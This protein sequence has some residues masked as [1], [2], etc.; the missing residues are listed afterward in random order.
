MDVNVLVAYVTIATVVASAF[1][2]AVLRPLNQSIKDLQEVIKDI[3]CDLKEDEER[4]HNL[5]VRVEGID[6]AVRSAHHRLNDH[7]NKEG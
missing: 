3:K 6:S 7:I 5:E 4:R 1:S 2:Y